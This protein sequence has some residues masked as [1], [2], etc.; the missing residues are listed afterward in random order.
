MKRAASVIFLK[1][2]SRGKISLL[3]FASGM[4]LFEFITAIAYPALGGSTNVR[5]VFET[6]GPD[7]QRLL[8]LAPN[9]QVGFGPANYLAFGYF[10]PVFL[11]LGSAF[12]VSRASDA[13]A[14]DIERGTIV[15][16]LSRPINRYIILLSKAAELALGLLVVVG[17]AV[18]GT[19]LGV[20]IT[21]LDHPLAIWPYAVI[22]LNAY[23][24][25]MALAGIALILSALSSSSAKVAGWGTAFALLAFVADFLSVLPVLNV[26]GNISPFRYYDP[27]GIVA[28]SGNPP[29]LSLAVLIVVG[30]LATAVAIVF[31]EHRDIAA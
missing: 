13:V 17:G 27:Q 22:G 29:W 3:A 1:T 18:L 15:F 5:Q 24:L 28:N 25:F 31:F 7:M 16:L 30:V 23:C 8:K 2:L 14:G 21:P 19:C 9:L 6:L 12:A 26:I 20:L 10:H 4:F 11:G